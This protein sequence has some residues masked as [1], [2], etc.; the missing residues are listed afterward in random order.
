MS[1]PPNYY[2][3]AGTGN[4]TRFQTDHR[5]KKMKAK[6]N[7]HN[8]DNMVSIFDNTPI[9]MM[10]SVKKSANFAKSGNRMGMQT[11]IGIG[12]VNYINGVPVSIQLNKA[13]LMN[14]S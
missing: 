7:D 2:R 13:E 12:Y 8:E 10:P 3:G 14:S 6:K 9:D 1:G 5:V 4:G 11:D